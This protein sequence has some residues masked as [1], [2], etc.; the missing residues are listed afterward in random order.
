[1]KRLIGMVLAVSVM[2]PSA[3]AAVSA[4]DT[5]VQMEYLDRGTVAVPNGMGAYISWRLLGTESYDTAFDV[6]RDGE[7]LATVSGSTNY[8]DVKIGEEYPVVPEGADAAS[9]KAV[10]PWDSEYLEIRLER[11]AGGISAD[12][13]EYTYSPNDVTPADVDGDGEYELILKW[14][15]SNSF[16]SGKDAKYNGSVYIDC[17]KLNGEKLWHIDMGCNINAGAHFTQMA[18][19]DDLF[20][21]IDTSDEGS[22]ITINNSGGANRSI[23]NCLTI[24]GTKNNACLIA[25]LF[26]NWREEFV[27]RGT[28]DASL[29]IYT[30]KLGT[31][32]KLYTL[33]HDRAYRMQAAC[34]NAGYNQPP[35]ISYYVDN[36]NSGYDTRKYQA[37]VKTVHNGETAVRTSNLPSEYV[38]PAETEASAEIPTPSPTAVSTALPSVMPEPTPTAASSPTQIPTPTPTAETETME[39][40]SISDDCTLLEA[41]YEGRV[42]K[43][44]ESGYAAVRIEGTVPTPTPTPEVQLSRGEDDTVVITTAKTINDTKLI[45][46]DDTYTEELTG[47]KIYDVSTD[48]MND[49]SVDI[50]GCGFETYD[51]MLWESLESM[52]PLAKPLPYHGS[53]AAVA[54]IRI[55]IR[56]KETGSTKIYPGFG[57]ADGIFSMLLKCGRGTYT[58]TLTCYKSSPTSRYTCDFTVE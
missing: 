56:N 18:A 19:Y 12:G 49:L 33:M 58:L 6:Y 38:K 52:K 29:I 35:H 50:S 42:Y 24:G 48:G 47:L 36:A 41:P 1:M 51:I 20:D 21:G 4:D 22:Y 17:Y 32:N 16:D 13:E 23:R 15:P 44:D 26:G 40:I 3:P 14:E 2:L 43:A 8:A 57:G 10:K 39:P 27:A 54:D 53:G 37:Y 46:L 55:A 11:P 34:Q 31:A 25:D 5:P 30:T 9:G 45:V 28:D 7:K